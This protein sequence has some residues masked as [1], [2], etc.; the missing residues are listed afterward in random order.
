MGADGPLGLVRLEETDEA[1]GVELVEREP[2]ALAP[3]RPV[4]VVVEPAEDL[5][6]V[7][8][9]VEVR[10]LVETAEELGRVVEGVD[11]THLPGGAGGRERALDRLGRPDVPGA[12]RRR[13][14]QHSIEHTAS[15]RR[16]DG[17]PRGPPGIARAALHG[18][19]LEPAKGDGA[20]GRNR[21]C[22]PR[23][24]RPMLYPTEL[25]ARQVVTIQAGAIVVE[26]KFS[27]RAVGAPT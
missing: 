20:P 19:L 6:R 26:L 4:E 25:Q 14:D 13:E 11:V 8:D 2:A 24:R 9:Q 23:L 15:L 10:L 3:P 1:S 18:A 12:G 16:R 22:D 21:T 27:R 17:F 7:V 5:R